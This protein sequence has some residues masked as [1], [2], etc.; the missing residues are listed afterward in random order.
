M[1]WNF[2]DQSLDFNAPSD[3]T[4]ISVIGN[5]IDTTVSDERHKTNIQYVESNF[6]DWVENV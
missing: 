1:R 2:T 6:C 3:N 5:I 4:N